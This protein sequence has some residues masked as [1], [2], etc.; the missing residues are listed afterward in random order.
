MVLTLALVLCAS[1]VLALDDWIPI[2]ESQD[3]TEA[4]PEWNEECTAE[5]EN[6]FKD[7]EAVDL[8][9]TLSIEGEEKAQQV[10]VDRGCQQVT[11]K[12]VVFCEFSKKSVRKGCKSA[13]KDFKKVL[14]KV[15]EEILG[16]GFASGK[17]KGF[18]LVCVK[19][20]ADPTFLLKQTVTDMCRAEIN[21]LYGRHNVHKD[22]ALEREAQSASSN[23]LAHKTCRYSSANRCKV[24]TNLTNNLAA[25]YCYKL[26]RGISPQV[27]KRVGCNFIQRG[28]AALTCVIKTRY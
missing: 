27:E 18:A 22:Y 2:T 4:Q 7:R 5:L 28:S 3:V 13:M 16:C 20:S 10:L 17:K 14:K 8:D 9:D 25:K 26:L 6:I 1:S 11:D 15:N 24:I 21:E 19:T 12:D 23:A